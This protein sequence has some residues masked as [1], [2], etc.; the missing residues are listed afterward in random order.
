[1]QDYSFLKT[2]PPDTKQPS[3][4]SG[5]SFAPTTKTAQSTLA[6]VQ[7]G[8]P[9]IG[10][11][12][13]E[14]TTSFLAK[15][16]LVQAI[17]TG[18]PSRLI[19]ELT[20]EGQV[21]KAQE[22]Y[23][24]YQEKLAT[25]VPK[26]QAIQQAKL[27]QEVRGTAETVLGT[28]GETGMIKK[29]ATIAAEKY[30]AEMTAKKEVAREA[31]KLG[32]QQKASALYKDAKSKLVDFTAPIEDTLYKAKKAGAEIPLTED[33]TNQIDRVLRAP[34]IAGDFVRRN[35]LEDVIR[36]VDNLDNLDQY[37]IAKQSAKVAER[38]IQTGRNLVAD[39]H[40]IKTLA[41]K[42]EATAQVVTDY[43]KKLLDYTTE[44]GLIS[45]DLAA[46]LK[47]IYPDYVP[48][49][50]VFNE[51][52]K[53]AGYGTKA[54]ASISKQNI[55]K[56]L[57]GSARE[58]ESPVASIL[59]KTADAFLQGEKNKAAK[60]LA[61]YEKLE[62]N[63]FQLRE[64]KSGE[65][66]K[67]TISFLD[68]GVKRT[69]ETTR[70]IAAAAKALNVQQLNILGEI[71]A[72]PVR[73]A[74]LGITG[75]NPAFILSNVAKDQ[76]TAAINSKEALAT[77]IA[78]P[79]KFLE[80]LMNAIGHGDVYQE[81]AQEGALGTS[82]DIARNQAEPTIERIRAGRSK[83]DTA[84]YLAKN[85]S[86]LLRAVENV[87]SRTE[88]LTR[89]QQYTGTK[90]KLLSQ[91]LSEEEARIGA[92]M[93]ARENTV[94]FA[95]RGEWGQVLNSAFLYLNAGIQ[96]SRTLVRNLARRPVETTSKIAGLILLPI[97]T[98]TAWNLSDPDR[99]RV[100]DSIA[101]YEK[102][103]NI[104]IVPNGA[105][106]NKDGTWNIIKIPLSQEINNLA[107][108]T[109]RPIEAIADSKPLVIQDLSNALIGTV[110]PFQPTARGIISTLT[111]QA[112]KPSIENIQNESLFTGAPQ[113]PLSL[114]RKT[115]K[116]QVRPWTSGSAIKIGN[117]IG[118]SP[119][120]VEEFL[121]GTFGGIA[122]NALHY[123]DEALA[124]IGAI[125]ESQIGG[126]G[127][128]ESI[129]ARFTEARTAGPQSTAITGG[130]YDFLK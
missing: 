24:I 66:A 11:V 96:G 29:E 72:A 100:Y 8:T 120:K 86:E 88:E 110:S 117:A 50:R 32:L 49:S 31:E 22:A 25:G 62:G 70:E 79:P 41:P 3:S 5:V 123:S 6:M 129:G 51:L 28:V 52:E 130:K 68:N 89:I 43:S 69:F 7:P 78:N 16:P 23:K 127:I 122:Q 39:Q 34:T 19:P 13:L 125:P 21:K 115:P 53:E 45:T 57:T 99:K 81:M 59:N 83:M 35:G 10:K 82:F 103:N 91:G 46:E 126:K 85:P 42:Y 30:V 90:Q 64:L 98:V 36:L 33:I 9:S 44:S 111:P 97:A 63:P 114:Q 76:V 80:S 18:Q 38:G 12:A 27:A 109:R 124:A 102:E 112:L 94:N 101:D 20:P 54:V 65:K 121:K 95:R 37:L 26:E 87:A 40:L 56:K 77:S 128:L 93:A 71:F 58:I 92:A 119:I 106:K 84:K 107:G 67:N 2:T 118:V 73:I 75:I 74:K 55:V 108:I 4:T 14:G 113:V 60:M 17:A 47:R 105:T 61:G 104:V 15:S 48:L 116:E 1:M